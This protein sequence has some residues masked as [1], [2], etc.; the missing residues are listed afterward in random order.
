M[1][2]DDGK[3]GDRIRLHEAVVD[4]V[5]YAGRQMVAETDVEVVKRDLEPLLKRLYYEALKAM[6]VGYHGA[7]V[8]GGRRLGSKE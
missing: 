3:R 1:A 6:P 5:L 7:R 2:I 4:V 8:G